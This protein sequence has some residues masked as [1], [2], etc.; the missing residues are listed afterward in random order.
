M[1]KTILITGANRGLGLEFTKQY[2]SDGW[3]VLAC[4]KD[5]NTATEL[6]ALSEKFPNVK[7]YSVDVT[8]ERSI[9]TLSESISS[10][11]DIL[12]NNAGFLEQD[13]LGEISTDIMQKTFMINAVGA[14]KMLEAFTPQVAKSE[15]KLIASLSSS[16]GSISDNT[17]GGYYSYRASKAALN[18]LMKSAAIDLESKK[19][20]VLLLHPGWVKTRMGGDG[21]TLQ[22]QESVK[23]MREVIAHYKPKPGE[24]QFIRY[25]GEIVPW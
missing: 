15:R 20:Q 14:L 12:L 1:T 10:P 8:N 5:L 7:C 24:V 6:K 9:F 19:I 16:M 3:Q 2:A 21:A 22:A 4:C 18:M 13:E 23:G 25:N 17:S 11:I